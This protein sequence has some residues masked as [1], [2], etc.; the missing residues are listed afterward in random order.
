MNKNNSEE[1]FE[2]NIKKEFKTYS[3]DVLKKGC[4]II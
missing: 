1:N 4:R 3:K 2:K